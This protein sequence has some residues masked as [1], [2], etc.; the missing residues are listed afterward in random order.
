M[1]IDVPRAIIIA[2]TI[3]AS[4]VFLT[5]G[6]YEFSSSN[7]GVAHRYNKITGSVDLCGLK[8]GCEPFEKK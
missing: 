6:F 4:S 2:A 8:S 5:N 7:F 1:V 3:I